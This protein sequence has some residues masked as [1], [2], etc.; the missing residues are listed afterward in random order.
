MIFPS[1]A[2]MSLTKL[3]L[4]GNNLIIPGH[5]EFGSWH[6]GWGRENRWLFLQRRSNNFAL[7]CLSKFKGTQDSDFLWL[8]FG[9]LYYFFV[10]CVKILR[11][12]IG[13][14]LGEVRFFREVLG[15]RRMKKNF[16]LVQKIFIFFFSFVNPFYEPILVFPKFD[17]ITAP[18][19]ALRVNLGPKCQNL[20]PL[21]WD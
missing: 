13:P 5:R 11:L 21:V 16:E 6:P 8:R 7:E 3:S 17:P 20:F 2:G 4:G 15:L 14:L 19:M 18:V 10:N 12:L 1:P 9:N